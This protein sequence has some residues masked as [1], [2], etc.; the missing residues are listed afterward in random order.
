[1]IHQIG[2]TKAYERDG[3]SSL[4]ALLTQRMALHPGEAQRLVIRAGQVASAPLVSFA[5]ARGALS[6]SGGNSTTGSR[7]STP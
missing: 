5:Y 7:A 4:T 1:M 6:S 2:E 3:Y